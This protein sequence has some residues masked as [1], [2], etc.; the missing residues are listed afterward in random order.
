M[1]CLQFRRQIG[2]EPQSRDPELLA[3]RD[4]CAQCM[5]VWQ[6]AQRFEQELMAAMAVTVPEGLVDRVLLA[7]S[8]GARQRQVSHR[9]G[10]LAIA[11]SVL[12]VV[13]GGSMVWR[14]TL[15]GSLPTLAVDHM[16]GEMGSLAMT[17]AIPPNSVTAGFAARGLSLRGPMPGGI[18]YVHDCRVGSY[19]AVHLVSRVGNMPVVALYLPNKKI[20]A[21]DGFERDGWKGREL[22]LRD[23]TLIVLARHPSE[24]QLDTAESDWR[25]AIDGFDS[26]VLSQL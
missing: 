10:W 26:P 25:A 23:G 18:T 13:G 16:A 24:Q 5:A 8:T 14:Q 1:N 21:P 15:S 9:R 19:A 3:H 12:I 22:P 6:R 2:A 4:E 7:Q 17:Q 20:A 11:A